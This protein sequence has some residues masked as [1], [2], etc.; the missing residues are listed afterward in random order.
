MGKQPINIIR[1]YYKDKHN[2]GHLEHVLYKMHPILRHP[3][4]LFI[5]SFYWD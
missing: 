5:Y 1:I 4:H 2:G 3:V